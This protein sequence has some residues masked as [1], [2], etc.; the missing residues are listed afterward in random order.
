[1]EA[2]FDAQAI[3]FGTVNVPATKMQSGAIGK[4]R[5]S[6]R[7]ARPGKVTVLAIGRAVPE[8]MIKNEGL[9][10]NFF[11]DADVDDPVLLAKLRRL[12]ETTTVKTRYVVINEQNLREN[13]NFLIEGAPSV[14]ER[15]R[16]SGD[17]V[18]K[19]GM[20]A[21]TE[22][23]REWGRLVS[24]IT[25]LVYVSSSEVRLPG[26]DLHLA[27][28]LGLRQD[29]NRVMLYMLG[30]YGG[31]SGIRVAKDLA[32]NNPGS[33]VL[34]VTSETTLIGYRKP[35]RDRPY[36]LVGAALFGDGAAAMILGT[37]PLP[38]TETP[39]FEL[40]WAG[41]CYLPGTETTIEGNL[42]EEGIIFKLGR[43]LPKIIEA[44]VQPFCDPIIKRVAGNL[45]YNDLFWA[46][47][48]G[49]P[50]ILSAVEKQLDLE[51]RKLQS[52]RQI[53][54]DYG[55]VSSSTCIYVLDH[56][57]KH[58]LKLKEVNEDV[59]TEPEWGVI[60]AFGP[61]ITIEGTLARS[62]S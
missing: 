11:R 3:E 49:G 6:G 57:R 47:H 48:P 50:A 24:D 54:A 16:I 29:V 42:T 25:H 19:L 61:G 26:G 56:M 62:L 53:L 4:C 5:R 27:K 41:Q 23:I 40:D 13:P 44:N 12:C 9:A 38:V 52:S 43:E 7:H 28:L 18:T 31:A 58:S 15:L 55:N 59:D 32:E 36:D 20:E 21:A 8:V 51:P 33:R 10:D 37:D 39:C 35:S 34:L 22:A 30:C 45:Q 2:T 1:M 60:L 14:G 46:V 17:A